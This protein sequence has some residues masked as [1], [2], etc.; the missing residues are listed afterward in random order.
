MGKGT[1]TQYEQH[2]SFSRRSLLFSSCV[3]ICLLSFLISV[4]LRCATIDCAASLGTPR[5]SQS[6]P[7]PPGDQ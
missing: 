2:V 4:I 1:E 6:A 7:P 5:L 3:P